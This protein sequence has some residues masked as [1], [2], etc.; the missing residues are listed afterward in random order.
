MLFRRRKQSIPSVDER[1]EALKKRGFLV[2][3]AA[4]KP[5]LIQVSHGGCAA[6]IE[7]AGEHEARLVEGPGVV[8]D[9]EIARLLDGGYQKF[10]VTARGRRPALAEQLKALLRFSERL[11]AELRLTTL[12]NQ[13][14]GSVSDTYQ[15]DRLRGR[16]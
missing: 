15:Y 6:V 12:Y 13:A 2:E 14:L 5:S 16:E 3:P 10:L 7:R 8:V 4:G 1:L 11:R 9:G